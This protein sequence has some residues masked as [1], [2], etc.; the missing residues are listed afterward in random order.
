[1]SGKHGERHLIGVE[2]STRAATRAEIYAKYAPEL[3]RFATSLVGP[4]DA[5]DVVSEAVVKSLWSPTWAS[6]VNPRAYL[7][8]AVLNESRM[9]HRRTTRR[10]THEMKTASSDM[11]TV[12]APGID[13]WEAMGSLNL[14]QRACVFLRY[15][16][17]MTT[18]EIGE[19]LAMS[20]RSVR[21][22][23]AHA[24]TTLGRILK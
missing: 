19:E 10:R 24:R 13:V 17:G 1:L 15:W 22:Q 16:E 21:R 14:P 9:H 20:T 3:A 8:Q 7:H 23:L 6:V 11:D 12:S 18:V 5:A 2:P 4:V